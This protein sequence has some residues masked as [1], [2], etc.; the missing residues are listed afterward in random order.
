M[1]QNKIKNNRNN[2]NFDHIKTDLLN[3]LEDKLENKHLS[4]IM[5]SFDMVISEQNVK[6]IHY[7]YNSL[8]NNNKISLIYG[9]Y[10]CGK[11]KTIENVINLFIQAQSK[12]IKVVYLKEVLFV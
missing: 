6:K 1:N 11:S 10:G 4:G 12:N 2:I 9:G 3:F 7:F 5:N 8:I